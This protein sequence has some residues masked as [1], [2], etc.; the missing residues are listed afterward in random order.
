MEILKLKL[1]EK[2]CL[3]RAPC[4]GQGGALRTNSPLLLTVPLPLSHILTAGKLQALTHRQYHSSFRQVCESQSVAFCQLLLLRNQ[5][6][7]PKTVAASPDEPALGLSLKS[8]SLLNSSPHCMGNSLRGWALLCPL[9]MTR[10]GTSTAPAFGTPLLYSSGFER[11]HTRQGCGVTFGVTATAENMFL[12]DST[13]ANEWCL[14]SRQKTCRIWIQN[15]KF[16]PEKE[17]P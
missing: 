5:P 10:A 3:S 6:F 2:G 14:Y 15:S 8:C 12:Q 9:G 1:L 7:L 11:A 16:N 17:S 4:I 13:S